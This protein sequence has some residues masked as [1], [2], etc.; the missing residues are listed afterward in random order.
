MQYRI[1]ILHNDVR[2][3]MPLILATHVCMCMCTID[4]LE[5][6]SQ[7]SV[8]QDDD[9]IQL[10]AVLSTEFPLNL[11]DVLDVGMLPERLKC[12][13]LERRKGLPWKATIPVQLL[14]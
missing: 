1:L 13:R 10:R 12:L 11:N 5:T 2:Q 9:H 3:H 14:H 7:I 8:P 6:T 4:N